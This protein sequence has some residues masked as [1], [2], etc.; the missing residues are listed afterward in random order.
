MSKYLK[1]AG[2][3]IGITFLARNSTVQD[4][5]KQFFVGAFKRIYCYEGYEYV[6]LPETYGKGFFGLEASDINGNLIK[7]SDFEGK[8]KAYL[9]M[10]AVSK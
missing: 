7:F 2:A 4:W 6:P 3:A 9:I 8:H 5:T 10:N 1:W